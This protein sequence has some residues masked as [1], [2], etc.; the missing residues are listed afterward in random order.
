MPRGAADTAAPARTP[1]TEKRAW[2]SASSVVCGGATRGPVHRMEPCAGGC[3]EGPRMGPPDAPPGAPARSLRA[4]RRARRA[5]LV[6][7]CG[8]PPCTLCAACTAPHALRSAAE[9]AAARPTAA[10]RPPRDREGAWIWPTRTDL[11]LTA[12]SCL[13]SPAPYNLTLTPPDHAVAPPPTR[14]RDRRQ[15]GPDGPGRAAA[16]RG[17]GG[18]NEET[19]ERGRNLMTRTARTTRDHVTARSRGPREAGTGT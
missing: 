15:A 13:A 19:A 18:S 7:P 17:E 4:R 16:A 14:S 10:P 2:A 9:S 3:A 12:R 5:Q 6:R 1:C 8:A 11:R